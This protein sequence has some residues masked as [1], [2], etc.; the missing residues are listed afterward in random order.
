MMDRMAKATIMSSIQFK[1]LPLAI[2]VA[3]RGVIAM[4]ASLEDTL[5]GLG[6]VRNIIPTTERAATAFAT[7]LE[8]LSAPKS[9][10]EIQALGVEV[11][12][13]DGKLRPTLDI[14]GELGIKLE[15]MTEESRK[16]WVQTVFGK[17]SMAGLFAITRQLNEQALNYSDT[18]EGGMIPAI[19]ALRKKMRE[20]DGTAVK[21]RDALLGTWKGMKDV[22]GA[23]VTGLITVLGDAFAKLFKPIIEQ[24]AKFANFMAKAWKGVPDP[25]K[26]AIAGFVALLAA[27]TAVT[28]AIIAMAGLIKII[29]V[30]F[31]T[32]LTAVVT[33][34]GSVIAVIV[35]TVGWVVLLHQVWVNNFG[36]IQDFLL[37]IINRIIFAFQVLYELFRTGGTLSE[38][39][40]KKLVKDK[41]LFKFV[42]KVFMIGS[43]VI[44]F[45]EGIA[46]AVSEAFDELSNDVF[47]LFDAIGE[48]LSEIIS[49]VGEVFTAVSEA[50]GFF[51]GGTDKARTFGVTVVDIFTRLMRAAIFITKFF[52]IP[53]VKSFAFVF[54]LVA[55]VI[56]PLISVMIFFGKLLYKTV[57]FPL[58]LMFKLWNEGWGGALGFLK[59]VVNDMFQVL[60]GLVNLII[61]VATGIAAVFIQPFVQIAKF[62]KYIGFG[63][64]VADKIIGAQD[65]LLKKHDVR[66]IVG[67]GEGGNLFGGKDQA[68]TLVSNGA[69]A[70]STRGVS[71]IGGAN[72]SGALAGPTAVGGAARDAASGGATGETPVIVNNVKVEVGGEGLPA[73]FTAQTNYETKRKGRLPFGVADFGESG[74]L[75]GND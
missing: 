52:I 71:G 57:F 51:D 5:I 2:G 66:E 72:K 40:G 41:S 9:K 7:S 54:K 68:G 49:V 3:A 47:P 26:K 70:A 18:I 43:R 75:W 8:K 37:P 22:L 64:S 59:E 42:A 16:A 53:A 17:R 32:G 74:G 55:K 35:A 62:M 15:Q 39:M 36:G 50:F 12:T 10:K 19:E 61:N 25:L 38:D 20:A 21:L 56:G 48:L 1:E 65:F 69:K 45:F 23:Q 4:N 34:F 27:T 46:G 33:I 31:A 30:I 13:L 63:E 11:A 6:L 24:F 14:I 67:V 28:G 44:A 29:G 58:I 73:I 60:A